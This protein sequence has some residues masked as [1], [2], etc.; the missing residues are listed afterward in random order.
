MT[1]AVATL[2]GEL[3]AQ[4]G[5]ADPP[6]ERLALTVSPKVLATPWP[7]AP[8]AMAAL[9]A[10]GLA[11]SRLHELRGGAP[12]SVHLD[13]RAAEIAMASSSYLEVAGRNAKFRDPFT[14]FYA[15]RNGEFVFLHGNFPHLRDGLLALLKVPNEAQAIAQAVA[16]WDAGELEAE[17]IKAGLCAAKV[18]ERRAW[19]AAPQGEAI[20]GQGVL[21]L[22]QI[23]TAPP[24]VLEPGER[25]AGLRALDLSRVIAGPMAA[26]SLAEHGAQVLQIASPKL[27]FIESLVIDTGFGKRAAHLDLDTDAGRERLSALAAEADIVIDAYRPGALAAR[28][29]GADALALM[30]PG[31]VAVGLSAFSEQG[32]WGG[33]RGYDSL[34]Q[35]SIGM[36]LE[37]GTDAPRLLPC[38]PLD[39]LTGYLAAFA[40]LAGVLR[41]LTE[42]GSW[43]ARLSL[44]ATANWMYEV[45][46]RLGDDRDVPDANPKAADLTDLLAEHQTAFGMVRAIVPALR[47]GDAATAWARPPVPLGSDAPIWPDRSRRCR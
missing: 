13:S 21:T 28:G 22:T 35:A 44:A 29:F 8:M 37:P 24:R 23:G 2:V 25:L 3:C 4:A 16:R 34:V 26:R 17:A 41:S 5:W 15:A 19:Q 45:R 46:A 42:G 20:A 36:A 1:H 10:L 40:A 30:R 33:R 7:I 43:Q 18:R 47:I 32:P 39:Y 14:G 11:V 38:Q 9:G 12:Q 31:V 6:L 27:P